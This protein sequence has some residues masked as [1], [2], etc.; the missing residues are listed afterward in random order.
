LC[1]FYAT[2]DLGSSVSPLPK[3]NNP[4]LVGF[5][6]LLVSLQRVPHLKSLLAEV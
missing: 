3:S 5:G 2:G 6:L 4:K 1:N